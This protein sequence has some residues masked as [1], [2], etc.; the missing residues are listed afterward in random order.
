MESPVS[1]KPSI[2]TSVMPIR[3]HSQLALTS[4]S[5]DQV[6][7]DQC[8]HTLWIVTR[9]SWRTYF[10]PLVDHSHMELL[11]RQL[12]FAF[13]RENLLHS[14]VVHSV[15]TS[16][17][18]KRRQDPVLPILL[19]TPQVFKLFE[20]EHELNPLGYWR[21]PLCSNSPSAARSTRRHLSALVEPLMSRAGL[22]QVPP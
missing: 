9:S 17:N 13:T 18:I 15:M 22:S 20:C 19:S 6:A 12:S 7:A 5:S 10:R 14:L 2:P 16:R 11:Q 3:E 1:L 8:K 21:I 4:P